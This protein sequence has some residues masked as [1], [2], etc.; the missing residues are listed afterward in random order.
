MVDLEGKTLDRYELRQLIGRG[1]MADVY[2]AYDPHFE[3]DVA[4]K[5]FKRQDD[6]MLRRFIR[7]AR[8][9]A[10]LHNP[11]LMPIYDTGEMAVDGIHRYYIVMPVMNDGTLR[12]RIRRAPLTLAQTCRYLRDI[13]SALDYVHSQGIIHRDIKSSNVLLN[14]D[15]L[16]YLSDFGIARTA[17]DAT[18]LTSTGNVL[19]TVDY[20]APELFEPHHK[21]D[22]LS[23]LYSLGVLLFEMVTGRLP[24]SG[25]TQIAVVA[26]HVSKHPP[27]PHTFVPDLP[28]QV[29]RIMLRSLEKN[30]S[31]RYQ[32]A[33]ELA[34]AF[35][36]AVSAPRTRDLRNMDSSPVW[37]DEKTVVQTTRDEPLV[38]PPVPATPRV[39]ESAPATRA[40]GVYPPYAPPEYPQQA[41]QI[42]SQRSR[43]S[44]ASKR[45]RIVAILA[46]LALLVV[47][48]PIIYAAT[49]PSGNNPSPTPT[50][51]TASTPMPDLTATAQIADATATAQAAKNATTTAQAAVTA[52]AQ[53]AKNATATAVVAPTATVRAQV[54]ATAG[55]IQTVT[56]GTASYIDPLTD[57]NNAATQK[58]KWDPDTT[59]CVFEANGYHVL[60]KAS[61]LGDLLKG[62]IETGNTYANMA[63][64]VDVT[65]VSGHSGGIFFRTNN[66][67]IGGAYAG[68]LFEVDSQG[69]YRI[70]RSSNFSLPVATVAL[71]DWTASPA[72]KPGDNV[73]NTLQIWAN[74]ETLDLYANN[75]FLKEVQDS[76]FMTGNIA[77]LAT[78]TNGGTDADVFYTNLQVFPK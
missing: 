44:S 16:C 43:T 53:A 58:A 2:L 59:H 45:G 1:G 40:T 10:S 48:V 22:A 38:L 31:L 28:P 4:I 17:N 21:A 20:I 7:E 9:M 71:Q 50:T 13:A 56:A 74:G 8:L 68:Y 34:N 41:P 77:L 30:P 42:A 18:Q 46:L 49:H 23:D 15:G 29:E 11:H 19:G 32:S 51:T 5:V 37:G 27:L 3:R 64:S 12:A 66:Q 57:P 67:G 54:T 39:T 78:T 76:T 24:F 63:A 26:M 60:Q 36:S 47:A 65:I 69:H 61:N 55:V 75:V 70:S 33:T 25:D 52:T 62:C 35:C 6:E 14:S 72:L 73:K